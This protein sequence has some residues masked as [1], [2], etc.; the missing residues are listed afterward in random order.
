MKLTYSYFS[1]D[2]EVPKLGAL[3]SECEHNEVHELGALPACYALIFNDNRHGVIQN[4]EG[5]PIS[6]KSFVASGNT[7]S[8]GSSAKMSCVGKQGSN[9]FKCVDAN[10]NPKDCCDDPNVNIITKDSD[11]RLKCNSSSSPTFYQCDKS[12]YSCIPTNRP[13]PSVGEIYY[14]SSQCKSNCFL[15]ECDGTTENTWPSPLS[16]GGKNFYT[17]I[18]TD[19]NFTFKIMNFGPADHCDTSNKI[20][21]DVLY[22]MTDLAC[23]F[24]DNT[25]YYWGNPQNPKDGCCFSDI[26]S[27]GCSPPGLLPSNESANTCGVF[28]ADKFK[29][30]QAVKTYQG[31]NGFDV[32][33]STAKIGNDKWSFSLDDTNDDAYNIFTTI[34]T[35][36]YYLCFENSEKYVRAYS[37]DNMPDNFS[38]LWGFHNHGPYA[39]LVGVNSTSKKDSSTNVRGFYDG[40]LALRWESYAYQ[41]INPPDPFTSAGIRYMAGA[42]VK[43][44]PSLFDDF[45]NPRF[46]KDNRN[47]N[48]IFFCMNK[49]NI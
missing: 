35:I 13:D 47:N 33:W 24:K 46:P 37:I 3:S 11:K 4:S 6:C 17:N 41:E 20:Q 2:N 21:G 15:K 5:G 26:N 31:F 38:K 16:E 23:M 18:L 43:N 19:E 27:S 28:S 36:K 22:G 48:G 39:I 45:N 25:K 34:G 42:T 1:N 12:S 14:S 7:I 9:E 30:L 44:N 8:G 49:K 29:Y 32:V 10:D 40:N